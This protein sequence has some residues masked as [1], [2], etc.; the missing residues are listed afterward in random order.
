MK[1]SHVMRLTV[2][3]GTSFCSALLVDKAYNAMKADELAKLKA[4][5][6]LKI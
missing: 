6:I 2:S 1:K 5:S 4:F 3:D